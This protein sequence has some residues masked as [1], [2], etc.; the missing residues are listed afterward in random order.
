MADAIVAA[1]GGAGSS[2]SD[3]LAASEAVWDALWS[4]ERRQQ[5][6]GGVG[7]M[8][9]PRATDACTTTPVSHVTQRR[10]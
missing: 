9:Q 6:R 1:L 7:S 5:V 3:V 10:V 8:P 4:Q 2:S